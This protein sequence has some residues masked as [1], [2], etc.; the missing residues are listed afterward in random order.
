MAIYSVF[1][2]KMVM[3]HGYVSLPEGIRKKKTRMF[4]HLSF[5]L[6]TF[7][8]GNPPFWALGPPVFP[9]RLCRPSALLHCTKVSKWPP[10][11]WFNWIRAS[12]AGTWKSLAD[13]GCWECCLVQENTGVLNVG[14]WGR[15]FNHKDHINVQLTWVFLCMFHYVPFIQLCEASKVY[16]C[17]K[18]MRD[19]HA[20]PRVSRRKMHWYNDGPRPFA[21]LFVKQSHK[22]RIDGLY[23]IHYIHLYT[24]LWEVTQ[25]QAHSAT[26]CCGFFAQD[27]PGIPPSL[28]NPWKS[29]R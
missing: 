15:Q 13:P 4:H 23:C 1:P 17:R 24:H 28:E 9:G 18:K 29:H 22:P 8:Q 6:P 19:F 2:L 11:G 25:W 26:E 3:F 16:N 7:I 20:A 12:N 5:Q 14:F 27:P 21:V 10:W